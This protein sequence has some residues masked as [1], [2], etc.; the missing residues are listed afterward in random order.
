MYEGRTAVYR[1]YDD[2]DRLLYVGI[3]PEPFDRLSQHARTRSWP[4]HAGRLTISWH[5]TR[6]EARAV[7]KDAIAT[8][9]PV[10]NRQGRPYRRYVQWMAAYPGDPDLID[11]DALLASA[12]ED[13]RYWG[14][15][16]SGA[17][18]GVD[19]DRV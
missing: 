5:D 11:P 3:S 13:G 10:F 7:E 14:V 4:S 16:G 2:Q 15:G 8:E 19:P 1:A 9:D 17:V 6:D 12:S 18:P